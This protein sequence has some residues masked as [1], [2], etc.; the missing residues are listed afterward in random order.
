MSI[1]G[2]TC[3]FY[4]HI[5]VVNMND[6]TGSHIRYTLAISWRILLS[7]FLHRCQNKWR[8]ILIC[9]TF[10]RNRTIPILLE[11]CPPCYVSASWPFR[12]LGSTRQRETF[13]MVLE[14]CWRL[15]QLV[16]FCIW[17]RQWST[18]LLSF[19]SPHLWKPILNDRCVL[20]PRRKCYL[21]EPN[22]HLPPRL[23]EH[24]KSH[25][26]LYKLELQHVY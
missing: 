7:P 26:V 11:N 9:N 8:L 16:V 17:C 15:V 13:F 24:I 5:F 22:T 21:V 2:L 14:G 23:W 20:F 4:I 18:C 10:E 12:I 6:Q 19:S 3:L 25:V 1:S